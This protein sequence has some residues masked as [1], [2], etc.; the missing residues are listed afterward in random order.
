MTYE[1]INR[2]KKELTLTGHVLY[3]T[4][5]SIS[6]RVNRKVQILQLHWQATTITNRLEDLYRDIGSHVCQVLFFAPP[7][8]QRESPPV[9]DS[10]ELSRTLSV[11][12]E[13]ATN[14]KQTVLQLDG[15]IREL[16][17]ETVQENLLK[18]QQEL[19][20]RSAALERVVVTQ[21][22]PAVGRTLAD[23][24]LPMTT[25]IVAVFRG[26]FL[27]SPAQSLVFRP[28]DVVVVLG[29]QDD[30]ARLLPAFFLHR[31]MKTA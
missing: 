10:V 16:K 21:G 31:S 28:N 25:R 26:P 17:I 23:L 1:F 4:I 19:S 11:A 9:L 3:E 30:L 24:H 8:A 14:L 22:A 27:V 5:L 12:A 13:T 7:A 18:V 2:I 29:L 6:E 15:L 20:I